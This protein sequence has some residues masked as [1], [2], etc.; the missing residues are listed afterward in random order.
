[1]NVGGVGH[2]ARGLRGEGNMC[3]QS[4]K[5]ILQATAMKTVLKTLQLSLKA[6]SKI[7]NPSRPPYFFFLVTNNKYLLFTYFITVPNY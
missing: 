4:Q 6:Q 5:L 1:M 2:A 7:P 3:R